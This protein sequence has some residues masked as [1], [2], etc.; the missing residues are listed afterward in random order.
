[1]IEVLMSIQ[2]L[3]ILLLIVT[4]I[5]LGSLTYF[6]REKNH[7]LRNKSDDLALVINGYAVTNKF[8][9]WSELKNTL[10]K[11][12]TTNEFFGEVLGLEFYLNPKLRGEEKYI[13]I[14][15]MSGIYE[16]SNQIFSMEVLRVNQDNVFETISRR[17]LSNVYENGTVIHLQDELGNLF[18]V[19]SYPKEVKLERSDGEEIYVTTSK[20]EYQFLLEN[21]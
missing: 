12:Y 10:V 16:K 13:R 9:K 7:D 11:S 14:K 19:W 18:Y 1:M 21:F 8:S 6:Y 3:L 20:D 17:R 2:K 4:N 15:P 5:V